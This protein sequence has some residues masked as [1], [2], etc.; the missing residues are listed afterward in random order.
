MNPFDEPTEE[1]ADLTHEVSAKKRGRPKKDVENPFSPA[2]EDTPVSDGSMS[3]DSNVSQ[4]DLVQIRRERELAELKR[5]NNHANPN[6]A[7]SVNE[8]LSDRI[9]ANKNI[10]SPKVDES[11][12]LSLERAEEIEEELVRKTGRYIESV[13]NARPGVPYTDRKDERMTHLDQQEFAVPLINRLNINSDGLTIRGGDIFDPGEGAQKAPDRFGTNASSNPNDPR[14]ESFLTCSN[15]QCAY[16]EGCLR[17]R[18]RN[19]RDNSFPFFP[20]SCRKDGI[21]ISV[22]DSDYT[23]YDNFDQIERGATGVTSLPSP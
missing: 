1:S 14:S 11:M 22:N 5:A 6:E 3:F 19:R 20:E 9:F 12:I 2:F 8:D 10:T 17:Y 16:R 7:P 13:D 21:Y 15:K 4:P 18:L 23:G